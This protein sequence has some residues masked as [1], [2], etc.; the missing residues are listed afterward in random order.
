MTVALSDETTLA[1]RIRAVCTVFGVSL[2]REGDAVDTLGG[3][4]G[5]GAPGEPGDG[6]ASSLHETAGPAFRR[7]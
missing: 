5:H 2:E 4:A 3:R 6:V 7:E 1:D